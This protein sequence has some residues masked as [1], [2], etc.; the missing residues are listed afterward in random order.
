V[1]DNQA[2]ICGRTGRQES[3]VN[4]GGK[5]L[6]LE[7]GSCFFDLGLLIQLFWHKIQ[8]G[9]GYHSICFDKWHFIDAAR[10]AA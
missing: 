8:A 5:P 7:K 2:S 3:A 9:V 4:Y 10:I 6:L 1:F